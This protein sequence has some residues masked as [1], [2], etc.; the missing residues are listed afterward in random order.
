MQ[1]F[2]QFEDPISRLAISIFRINGA[3]MRNGDR[4]TR[5]IGQS[6]ARWHV[7]GQAAFKPQTVASIARNMGQ[8]RQSVQRVADVL[9][10]EG[11]A[12]YVD[13][14]RDK[15]AR[16]LSVSPVGF[17]VLAK[18]D[19]QNKAWIQQVEPKLAAHDMADINKH[20]EEIAAILEQSVA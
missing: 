16:L 13:N 11:L 14:P 2:P 20:L 10:R 8:A 1:E 18:I 15:R 17:E 4:I 5:S 12:S 3:L 6:S 19:A 9:V 7:L